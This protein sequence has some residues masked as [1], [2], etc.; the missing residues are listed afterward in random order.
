[1]ER[2]LYTLTNGEPTVKAFIVKYLSRINLVGFYRSPQKY[3]RAYMMHP[4]LH[5]ANLNLHSRPLNASTAVIY[6]TLIKM[7]IK[8]T[9]WPK[10][11]FVLFQLNVY[12]NLKVSMSPFPSFKFFV[13]VWLFW[14]RISL[15]N[16]KNS[17]V[18]LPLPLESWD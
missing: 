8:Q 15:D 4:T 14:D 10:H 12:I 17:K 6:S 2:I 16:G 7:K 5:E 13:V 18:C 9:V 3:L 1:M 11:C